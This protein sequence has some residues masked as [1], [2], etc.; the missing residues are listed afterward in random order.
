MGDG[1]ADGRGCGATD[2]TITQ[3]GRDA[4]WVRAARW[5]RWLAWASLLWMCAEGAL[6]L[7]QGFAAGSIALIGWALGSAVEGL[8]SVIVVWRFTGSRTLSETSERRAQRGVALSFWLIAPYIAVESVRSLLTGARPQTTFIGIAL[9]AVAVVLMPLLGSA[10][11]RLGTRLESR[12]TAGEGTQNYLCAAQ[13]AAVLLTLTVV[14]VWPGG[15]W[16]D[17]AV[18]L[19]IAG[20][21]VREGFEAWR[22]EECGC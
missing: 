12:A 5:A 16:L 18:G 3:P 22:G 11:R 8:A 19:V 1:C 10:K 2:V 17:P 6:G 21:A 7:W 14:A 9:T 4:E 20:L 15:W 13:S